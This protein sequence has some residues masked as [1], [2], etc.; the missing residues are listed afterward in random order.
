[1]KRPA[2]QSGGLL[3]QVRI[4]TILLI[5]EKL[6]YTRTGDAAYTGPAS[7]PDVFNTDDNN[8][9]AQTLILAPSPSVTATRVRASLLTRSKSRTGVLITRLSQTPSKAQPVASTSAVTL[10]DTAS[11]VFTNTL[12]VKVASTPL[13]SIQALSSSTLALPSSATTSSSAITK[14][15]SSA[16]S[17]PTSDDKSVEGL[18]NTIKHSPA[19]IVLAALVGL[20]IVVLLAAAIAFVIRRC[21]LRRK[22]AR[23]A[24][25]QRRFNNDD[26]QSLHAEKGNWYGQPISDLPIARGKTSR[27]E[28]FITA[29]VSRAPTLN[30]S[31]QEGLIVP[32]PAYLSSQQSSYDMHQSEFAI[33]LNKTIHSR[34]IG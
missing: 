14:S 28:S 3:N 32:S 6:T 9:A 7:S 18:I 1:M 12:A 20:A 31:L 33:G 27:A 13:V 17:A 15:S 34:W 19:Y 11:G 4:C 30:G 24:A 10:E 16:A 23:R 22:K 25:S 5:R 21:C 26:A 29:Q 2:R 8:M